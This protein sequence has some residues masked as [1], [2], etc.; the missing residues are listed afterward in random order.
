MLELLSSH[1]CH[2]GVQRFYRHES[3]TIGLPMRFSVYL[4]PQALQS[5]AKVPAL[6]YLAG[7]TCT[8][9]TFAI[10]AGAQRFAAQHGVAL[11]APDTSPRGAGVP[12]ESAAWDFGVG[13]GFY[14]DATQE[15]WTRHYRMYSYVRDELRETVL[16]ELP[17]DA[18]RLG[19]FGHSMGGHGALMLAL[20]NPDIYRSVS[21]FAP[22]A[23]PSRCPWGEKA[24]SGYLG[25][26]REA[27]KAYDASELVARASRR[28]EEGIL[29]DQGLADAFL[30]EQLYPDVFEAACE[31]AGQPLTL[32]RHAGYDHG[33]YFISTFIEDH[34]AHHAKVLLG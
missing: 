4:P 16:A 25:D 28:F 6:F 17:V 14:V 22:I 31:A 18:A 10:K 27:W 9:E 30:A 29:V 1:A 34:I 20:R 8:E 13:A 19:I 3:R 11:V 26:N 12:G 23:A 21:A 33:Y 15:P 32:R 7:L 2:G 24:F 5:N